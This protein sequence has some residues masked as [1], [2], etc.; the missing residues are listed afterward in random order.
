MPEDK[1]MAKN[2]GRER[3]MMYLPDEI[4]DHMDEKELRTALRTVLEL[5]QRL[6]D[7]VYAKDEMIEKL[8]LLYR[9]R[10]YAESILIG[11]NKQREHFAKVLDDM[12][13]KYG[14]YCIKATPTCAEGEAR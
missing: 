10:V 2:V 5:N 7:L 4:I 1:R 11:A 13:D 3:M 9:D 8:Q 6:G 14:Q 12:A